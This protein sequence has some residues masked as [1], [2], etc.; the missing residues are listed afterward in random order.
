MHS[1]TVYTEW[2]E[3]QNTSSEHQLCGWK[4]LVMR[5]VGGKWPDYLCWQEVCRNSNS[6]SLQPLWAEKHHRIH[7]KPWCEC[8]IRSEIYIGFHS[9]QTLTGIWSNSCYSLMSCTKVIFGYLHEWDGVKVFLLKCP[10]I[11]FHS[12]NWIGILNV[13][14]NEISPTILQYK[15]TINLMFWFFLRRHLFI[16]RIKQS[17]YELYLIFPVL[18]ICLRV[19]IKNIQANHF[20]IL[21]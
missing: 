5:E 19:N 15:C 7:I 17:G 14:S 9:F 8:G 13:F 16:R 1:Y 3:I 18:I 12:K 6:Q 20:S 11:V 21:F 4:R 10:V 2:C